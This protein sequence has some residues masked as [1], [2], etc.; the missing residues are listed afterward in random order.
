MDKEEL[1][2]GTNNDKARGYKQQG[3]NKKANMV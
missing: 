1:N 3:N 2:H